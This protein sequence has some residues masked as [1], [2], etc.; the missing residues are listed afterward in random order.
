MR[1]LT[2]EASSVDASLEFR[3]R[4]SRPVRVL[5]LLI[6]S[7]SI[8]ALSAVVFQPQRSNIV[9]SGGLQG[10]YLCDVDHVGDGLKHCLRDLSGESLRNT[11]TELKQSFETAEKGIFGLISLWHR[12]LDRR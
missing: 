3:D 5:R 8:L 7:S 10:A 9:I 4:C 2:W 6:I 12:R 11:S 1:A